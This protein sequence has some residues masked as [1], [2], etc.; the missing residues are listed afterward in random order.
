MR[1]MLEEYL[2]RMIAITVSAEMEILSV[3]GTDFAHLDYHRMRMAR[4]LTAYQLFAHREMFHALLSSRHAADVECGQRLS[5]ECNALA[6]AMRAHARK[7]AAQEPAAMWGEYRPAALGLI[8]R[9][10]QHILHARAGAKRLDRDERMPAE[11]M[12]YPADSYL[13]Q[14]ARTSL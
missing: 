6:E 1:D 12:S 2:E 11:A 5:V 9:I 4:T 13:R 10:R 7:W 3:S 8:E 14:M